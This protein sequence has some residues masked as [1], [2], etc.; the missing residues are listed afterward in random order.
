LASIR[1]LELDVGIWQRIFGNKSRVQPAQPA[2]ASIDQ[3]DSP[4]RVRLNQ[5]AQAHVDDALLDGAGQSIAAFLRGEPATA[6][7][8]HD[9]GGI[10]VENYL[11]HLA[12]RTLTLKEFLIVA[13]LQWWLSDEKV[14]SEALAGK[15]WTLERRHA[16]YAQCQ[17]IIERP[18][19]R[20]RVMAG[21]QSKSDEEF[22]EAKQA[23]MV[24]HIYDAV[25]L[26]EKP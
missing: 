13:R 10:V 24:L 6:I 7:T 8:G 17:A 5:L 11:R 22:A 23:A 1:D 16:I 14:D 2:V 3:R 12:S 9:D 21:L 4:S 15:G 20:E 26:P 19:W 25:T 18:V